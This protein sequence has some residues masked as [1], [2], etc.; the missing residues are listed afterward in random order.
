[1]AV[2]DLFPYLVILIAAAAYWAV[3]KPWAAFV[4]RVRDGRPVARRGKVTESFLRVVEDV[5]REFGLRS[6][7]VW[8]VRR[9]RRIALG[10]SPGVPAAAR[11]RL[12]NWWSHSGWSAGPGRA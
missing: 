9:G 8:G 4:V 5:F 10:F 11:Q 6:G 7:A 1:M 3:A 12:R 2:R